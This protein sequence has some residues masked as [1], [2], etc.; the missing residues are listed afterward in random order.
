ME[1]KHE[2]SGN[3]GRSG[4]GSGGEPRWGS[5]KA[6]AK[7][8]DKAGRGGRTGRIGAETA[9][10]A[11]ADVAEH[12]TRDLARVRA[13]FGMDLV[14]APRSLAAAWTSPTAVTEEAEAEFVDAVADCLGAGLSLGVALDCWDNGDLAYDA[15]DDQDAAA[16]EE[17]SAPV[18][19]VASRHVSGGR[20]LF[21]R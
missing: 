19:P 9:A 1:T 17:M 20:R 16:D 14:L 13:R 12:L 6:K 18:I 4:D 7:A 5:Q 10:E 15:D 11:A 21:I 8:K 2:S 3:D